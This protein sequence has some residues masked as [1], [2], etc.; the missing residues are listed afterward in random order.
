MTD[1]R[2]AQALHEI[3]PAVRTVWLGYEEDAEGGLHFGVG[4]RK[5]C[6][7]SAGGTFNRRGGRK[8]RAGILAMDPLALTDGLGRPAQRRAARASA[9]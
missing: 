1:E 6:A 4:E 2:K 7:Q 8:T 5:D 9:P 3:L